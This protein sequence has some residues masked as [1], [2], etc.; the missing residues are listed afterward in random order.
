MHDACM[1]CVCMS[2][3]AS[4]CVHQQLKSTRENSPCPSQ[5]MDV[6]P[7]LQALN[8]LAARSDRATRMHQQMQHT[9][10]D[11]TLCFVIVLAC[12]S[13]RILNIFATGMAATADKQLRQIQPEKSI[14]KASIS[15]PQSSSNITKPRPHC[16]PKRHY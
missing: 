3:C 2:V 5:Q 10:E 12:M 1:M 6:A 4:V 7:L 11:I 15:H 16:E 9:Q 13:L 8:A 14:H